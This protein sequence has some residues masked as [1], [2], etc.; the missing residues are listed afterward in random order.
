[1][2]VR[3]APALVFVGLVHSAALLGIPALGVFAL[4]VVC[5]INI[6]VNRLTAGT[7]RALLVWSALAGLM[8]LMFIGTLGG[9][10]DLAK[11]ILLPPVVLNGFFLYIF[12][13][14]LLPGREP[15]ISRMSRLEVGEVTPELA[16]YTKRLSIC[17]VVFFAV[18]LIASILLA[19]YGD[20]AMWSWITNLAGPAIGVSLFL[21]E[22]L[23]RVHRFGHIRPVS[24]LG[25]LRAT[26][27]PGAWTNE[28]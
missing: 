22:H 11:I 15:L 6:I 17:W 12:G 28:A 21:L 5:A 3:L 10:D 4:V 20:L 25:T 18:S 13:R 16:T 7:R 2:L 8:I 19:L 14:T 26:L 24:I 23:Y 1:M 9:S 27:R